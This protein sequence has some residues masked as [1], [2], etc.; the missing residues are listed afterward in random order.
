MKTRTKNLIAKHIRD[1]VMKQ[2]GYADSVLKERQKE[3]L[4]AIANLQP[5]KP[6]DGTLNF[7]AF[8]QPNK[9][10]RLKLKTGRF[11]SRKLSLN[12]GFLDDKT[13]QKL[14][15]TINMELFGILDGNVKLIKGAGITEHYQNSF[16][17]SSCM[18]GACNCEYTRLYEQ[19]PDRFS[20]LTMEFGKDQARAIVHKLDNGQYLMDRVYNSSESLHTKMVEH[21]VDNGYLHRVSNRAVN[22][23]H[24]EIGDYSVLVVSDLDF[25]EGHVPYMDTLDCG[26]IKNGKLTVFHDRAGKS[27]NLDL[28]STC[29]YA[30]GNGGTCYGCEERV[31]ED[32]VYWVGD[33]CWCNDCYSER[34]SYCEQCDQTVLQEGMVCI[35]DKEEWVCNSCADN[36]YAQCSECGGYNENNYVVID[37]GDGC[38][39]D[40]CYENSNYGQCDE[41]GEVLSYD[42][43]EDVNDKYY[44]ESCK[45]EK[46]ADCEGQ[47]ELFEE[48]EN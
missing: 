5:D 6:E 27:P 30:E 18:S 44:C 12:G 14:S 25:E 48:V 4:I 2:N 32:A 42:D 33:H 8:N 20:M 23:G 19:N 3:I 35:Q 10:E 11:L 9:T 15:D 13:L 41:C 43:L 45:N 40:D 47:K 46:F 38:L 31:S 16:G 7:I 34:F 17:S 37:N 21:A 28:T 29:G 26:V 39:C 1:V 22:H 36:D 24:G